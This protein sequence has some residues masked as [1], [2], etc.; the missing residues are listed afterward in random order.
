VIPGTTAY[1]ADRIST[2]V[3]IVAALTVLALGSIWLLLDGGLPTLFIVLGVAVGLS[4]TVV[5]VWSRGRDREE[6]KAGYTTLRLGPPRLEQRHPETGA[7]IREA[8]SPP[9]D[10]AAFRAVL[11]GEPPTTDTPTD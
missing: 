4:A 3:N 1:R 2:I 6:Q 10:P 9:L 11:A 5:S 7:V 8:G